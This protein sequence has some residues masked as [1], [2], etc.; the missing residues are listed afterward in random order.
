MFHDPTGAPL[1]FFFG[2]P[3]AKDPTY[4]RAGAGTCA[5]LREQA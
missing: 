1:Y 3:S 4:R 2:F 5:V